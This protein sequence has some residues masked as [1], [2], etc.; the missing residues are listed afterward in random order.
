M[1]YYTEMVTEDPSPG[2]NIVERQ[3]DGSETVVWYLQ[4]QHSRLILCEVQG[5]HLLLGDWDGHFSRFHIPTQTLTHTQT[6]PAR[7]STG[8]VLSQSGFFIL[9]TF[10]NDNDYNLPT[11]VRLDAQNL[12]VLRDHRLPL[13]K[14]DEDD[15]VDCYRLDVFRPLELMPGELWMYCCNASSGRS[16]PKEHEFYRL[17]MLTGKESLVSLPDV[18]NANDEVCMPAL[19]LALNLGVMLSWDAVKLIENSGEHHGEKAIE[20]ALKLFDINKC[21]VLRA[22]PLRTYRFS[23]LDQLC[24]D[25]DV[26]L[27]GP[28][29]DLR[30]YCSELSDLYEELESMC[31]QEDKLRLTFR[32]QTVLMDIEGN[33]EVIPPKEDVQRNWLPDVKLAQKLGPCHLIRIAEPEQA[34]Q[35]MVSM[36]QNVE[37]FRRGNMLTFAFFD[38]QENRVEPQEF[39]EQHVQQHGE[40]MKQMVTAY[41]N[42]LDTT[43]LKTNLWEWCGSEGAL[44]YVVKALASTGDVELLPLID[45]YV[46]FIDPDHES[47]VRE[48]LVPYIQT[49]FSEDLPIVQEI[50]RS[51]EYDDGEWYEED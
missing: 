50:I 48:E 49:K 7:I 14:D 51:A 22:L 45:R 3:T 40:L 34:L 17:E 37:A 15:E 2:L 29:E 26:L 28:E 44:C 46:S 11:L 5:E 23:E 21:E 27:A 30:D 25:L 8:A 41:C 10:T 18:G 39:F 13:Q 16:K 24:I 47:F 32:D 9:V 20:L 19:N 38:G 36:C 12:S 33:R 4:T 42:Y 31:W 43:L 1:R 6:L 35:K